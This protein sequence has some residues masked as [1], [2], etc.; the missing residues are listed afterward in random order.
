MIIA[1]EPEAAYICCKHL[2][3]EELEGTNTVSAFQSGRKYL[4]LDAGGQCEIAK[5]FKRGK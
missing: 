1:L 2:P 4:V 5:T 3:V